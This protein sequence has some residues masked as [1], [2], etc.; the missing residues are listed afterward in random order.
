LQ[1]FLQLQK[2]LEQLAAD[3]TIMKLC[4]QWHCKLRCP[5]TLVLFVDRNMTAKNTDLHSFLGPVMVFEQFIAGGMGSM[6]QTPACKGA[7]VRF[8]NNTISIRIMNK[9]LEEHTKMVMAET[10]R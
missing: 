5:S 2:Y 3:A 1:V 9:R 10:A 4:W 6:Q 8:T 7:S